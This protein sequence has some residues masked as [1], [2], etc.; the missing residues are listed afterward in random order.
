MS[1]RLAVDGSLTVINDELCEG[2]RFAVFFSGWQLESLLVLVFWYFVGLE[3][4]FGA[5]GLELVESMD[6]ALHDVLCVAL[7]G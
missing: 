5:V 1:H 6:E 3:L 4:W 7:I 2:N